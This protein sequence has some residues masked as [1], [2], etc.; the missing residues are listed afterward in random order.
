MERE[1]QA[2]LHSSWL[3]ALRRGFALVDRDGDGRVS[4]E[5]LRAALHRSGLHATP[6]WTAEQLA[7]Y[8]DDGDGVIG[9]ADYAAGMVRLHADRE[10]AAEALAA[11]FGEV[12]SDG[13]GRVTVDELAGFLRWRGMALTPGQVAD[14]IRPWDRDGD[15]RIDLG[16]LV[17]SLLA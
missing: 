1:I 9:F 7:Q 13:D 2:F 4:A 8:D 15:G 3:V 11:A 10:P 5:D 12:D 16:E 17:R 14:R 6:A